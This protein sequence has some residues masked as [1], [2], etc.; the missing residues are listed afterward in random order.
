MRTQ[1]QQDF[2]TRL[3]TEFPELRQEIEGCSGQ[4]LY[5]MDAFA[6]FTQAAKLRGDWPVY[7]RCIQLADQALTSPDTGLGSAFHTAYLE[8]LEF[9][10]SRGPEAWRRLS[11]PL[12][13]AWEQAAAANRRLMALPQKGARAHAPQGHQGRQ[14]GPGNGP[15]KKKSSSRKNSRGRRR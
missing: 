14:G 6:T 10:G 8:H 7:E 4:V 5:E 11:P 15:R 12:Q 13:A 9:E 3:V 2:A 1:A